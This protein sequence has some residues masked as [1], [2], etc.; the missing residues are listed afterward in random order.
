M[1]GHTTER[2]WKIF[3][4]FGLVKLSFEGVEEVKFIEKMGRGASTLVI[5]V[6]RTTHKKANMRNFVNTPQMYVC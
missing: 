2:N 3:D 5:R 4:I 6:R 1:H